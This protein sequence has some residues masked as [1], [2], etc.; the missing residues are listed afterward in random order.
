MEQQITSLHLA[1]QETEYEVSTLNT[2]VEQKVNQISQLEQNI[3]S[4]ESTAKE[5]EEQ[6]ATSLH[7][8]DSTIE[9]LQKDLAIGRRDAARL[10]GESERNFQDLETA[11]ERREQDLDGKVKMGDQEIE[12]LKQDIQ[13]IHKDRD[14]IQHNLETTMANRRHAIHAM[15]CLASDREIKF[16]SLGDKIVGQCA[17]ILSAEGVKIARKLPSLLFSHPSTA[18]MFLAIRFWSSAF[19]EDVNGIL[20][21]AQALFKLSESEAI[22]VNWI[23]W[24]LSPIVKYLEAGRDQL[25]ALVSAKLCLVVIQS[26]V[27]LHASANN[28]KH[29]KMLHRIKALIDQSPLPCLKGHDGTA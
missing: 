14:A 19:A 1:M 12:K 27:L 11:L 21:Y 16:A 6:H 2:D 22:S 7:D 20:K 28:F 8:R 26:M 10:N 29:S 24:G 18:A 3:T 4:L 15:L 9:T 25:D 17:D 23:S 5:M 13:A